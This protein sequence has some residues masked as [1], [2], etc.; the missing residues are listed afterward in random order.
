MSCV[1]KQYFTSLLAGPRN[2]RPAT[3][4]ISSSA[5]RESPVTEASV[6]ASVSVMDSCAATP[7]AEA[8]CVASGAGAPARTAPA[9]VVNVDPE[10]G[11]EEEQVHLTGKRYKNLHL[12]S[13][14]ISPRKLR[15]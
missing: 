4:S 2:K 15:L 5:T 8:S 13:G 14:S 1:V 6:A 12:M 7:N 10:D 9:E 11:E 3:Q